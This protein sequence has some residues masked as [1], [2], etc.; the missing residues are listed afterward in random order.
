MV[1][2]SLNGGAVSWCSRKQSLVSLS[3]AEAEY[4]ALTEAVKEMLYMERLMKD[5]DIITTHPLTIFTDSQNCINMLENQRASSRTKHIDTKYHYVR[6]LVEKR[7]IVLKYCPSED[8]A[9]DLFTKP[10]GSVKMGFFAR[11]LGLTT[12]LSTTIEEEC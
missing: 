7:R 6:D 3:S 12:S 4:I 9:A 1:L 2:L 10:L 8:N 11:R 5:F